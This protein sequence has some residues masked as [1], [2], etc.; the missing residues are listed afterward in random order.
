M[1][2]IS[3]TAKTLLALCSSLTFSL[4][5]ENWYEERLYIEQTYQKKPDLKVVSI[6]PI[7]I[8]AYITNP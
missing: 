4:S 8:H 5:I 2:S 3:K 7:L 6:C 1:V